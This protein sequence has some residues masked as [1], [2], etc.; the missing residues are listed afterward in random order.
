[1]A[2]S[3]V[4]L[5]GLHALSAL[6]RPRSPARALVRGAVGAPLRARVL[7]ADVDG[8]GLLASLRSRIAEDASGVSFAPRGPDE[9]GMSSMTPTDVAS[10]V[11]RG[12]ARRE[13]D[14]LLAFS[15]AKQV[16]ADAVDRIV[17]GAFA[18]SERL[19]LHVRDRFPVLAD[20]RQ[21][22]CVLQADGLSPVI[23][24]DFGRRATQQV[25]ILARSG[26]EGAGGRGAAWS[27]LDMHL[28]LVPYQGGRDRRWVI[29]SVDVG[30][31]S[32]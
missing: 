6:E 3:L 20:F 2:R 28:V 31:V 22:Q 24:R 29:T 1:M 14:V 32:A 7:A 23:V 27:Q 8:D 18:D 19:E 5:V 16:D 30:T 15:S 10:H 9:I 12:L 11:M 21:W 17:P 26:G 25:R 4:L 13:W